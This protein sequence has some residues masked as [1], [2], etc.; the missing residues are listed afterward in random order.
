MIRAV[1]K[2]PLSLLVITQD[3]EF[4][5]PA[6]VLRYNCPCAKCKSEQVKAFKILDYDPEEI[7]IL[8]VTGVGNYGVKINFSDGHSFGIF[9]FEQLIKLSKQLKNSERF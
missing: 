4:E 6:N 5:I 8:S 1:I 9:T 2:N 7:K 3:E